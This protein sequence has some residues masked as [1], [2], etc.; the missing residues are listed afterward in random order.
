MGPGRPPKKLDRTIISRVAAQF[1]PYRP[2]VTL[3][4]VLVMISATIGLANPFLLKHLI[5]H[6]LRANNLHVITVDSLLTIAATLIATAAGVAYAYMSILVGQGI[7][8]DLRNGL[9]THLQAMP[10]RWFTNVRTGEMQSRITN[11]VTSVQGAVSD[12]LAN[13]LN[14][15]TT[16]ISTIVAMLI[17]DWRLTALSVGVLP[18]FALIAA[19]V[20]KWADVERRKSQENL[21]ALTA[22]TNEV[23]NV[24][25]A[26]LTKVSGRYDLAG[27]RFAKENAEVAATQVRLQTI[28]RGFFSLFG[29]TFTI[30]PTLVFWLAGYLIIG[31]RDANLSL[32]TIIAFTSMQGRLFFPVTQLLNVQVELGSSVSLFGRIFEYLDLVPEIRDAENPT[33]LTP[34]DIRGEVAFENVGFRYDE[35]QSRPTLENIDLRADAGQLVALVGSSG[36]GKTSLT[37]LIPR[38]YDVT[39]GR[40]TI[41]GHDVRDISLASLGQIIGFVTQET[42]LVHDTIRENLRY[43]RSDAT[44]EQIEEAAKAA[45]IHNHIM[46]LPDGYATVVGERG[47]KLSGG[48]KQRISIARA[49]LKD[50]RVLILDEA[51]SALDTQSERLVQGALERLMPGRTTFAIAHRLSTVRAADLI[52]VM[53]HG[54]I[55]ERGTHEELLAH[56]GEY[57]RLYDLQ[58]E[59]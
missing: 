53:S 33:H 8:R 40:V 26:L 5:D 19:K 7:M 59:D 43:G 1:R 34:A 14:N 57:R 55:V 50:P 3:I 20:G 56:G 15:A 54:R 23:L 10:L 38:L 22:T 48:E 28:M 13:V 58:F 2:Q 9:F 47:Y 21:A 32:G 29:L 25:G 46:S 16:A 4:V 12:T 36:A 52:V 37:Y 44:D 45:A 11:D 18:F 41:D 39:E 31:R 6:G 49:I 27:E 30:T 35:N 42:Y 51:T 17:L 24:S